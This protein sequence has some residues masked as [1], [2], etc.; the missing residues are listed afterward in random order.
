MRHSSARAVAPRTTA[1]RAKGRSRVPWRIEVILRLFGSA[2]A[3]PYSGSPKRAA[4]A[5]TS[6]ASAPSFGRRALATDVVRRDGQLDNPSPGESTM[7]GN[8]SAERSSRTLEFGMY[9]D[10]DNNLDDI[11]S[12]VIDQ[13]ARTSAKDRAIEFTVEDTTRRDGLASDGELRTEQYTIADGKRSAN[14]K[15]TQPHDMSSRGDLA[16]FVATTLD[17]AEAA[18]AKQTWIDLIDHGGGDAGGLQSDHSLSHI[19]SEDDMAGAIA[20]GVA[21]HAK[22][23]P[24][25]RRPPRR[26]GG[27]ESVP[28]VDARLRRRALEVGRA[29]PR[30]VARDDARS[31][32]SDV[33]RGR[34]RKARRRC[35]RDGE[36]RRHD[37]DV[38]RVR[39]RR[40]HAIR[41][42]PPLSTFS[43]SIPKK[44]AAM[45]K[46]V[47]A[48]NAA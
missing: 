3:R 47:G 35:E 34:H 18:N 9:R 15:V 20:D 28:D 44:I 19:M 22:A 13:A 39:R 16:R 21:M 32:R 45:E 14:P 33:G 23:H 24:G 25:R 36:S 8:I 1:R 48:L 31:R 40:R 4:E 29:V 27:R 46:S 12:A 38:D 43:T 30:R 5:P 10:G 41:T 42:P 26:R 17:H 37:D 6:T 2:A 11:Q 7:I